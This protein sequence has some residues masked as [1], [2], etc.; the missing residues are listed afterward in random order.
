[1]MMLLHHPSV[2]SRNLAWL[3]LW[4]GRRLVICTLLYVLINYRVYIC[5]YMYNKPTALDGQSIH[6]SIHFQIDRSYAHD[7]VVTYDSVP[8]AVPT[9][10]LFLPTIQSMM[11]L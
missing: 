3:I 2:I 6:P 5:I 10:A 4:T 7:F 1:M 8:R 11:H 9:A